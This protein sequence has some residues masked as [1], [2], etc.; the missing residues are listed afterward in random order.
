MNSQ[1]A[2]T[3]EAFRGLLRDH[4]GLDIETEYSSPGAR[5]LTEI[6]RK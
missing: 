1:Y 5:F 4:G 2:Y 6:C 3:Q